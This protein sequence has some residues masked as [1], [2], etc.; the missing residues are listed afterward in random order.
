M[1]TAEAFKSPQRYLCPPQ[2]PTFILGCLPSYNQPHI[3]PT[4][5]PSTC[6]GLSPNNVRFVSLPNTS[7]A[8][9]SLRL[10]LYLSEIT[11]TQKER[12][13]KHC[14]CMYVS[15]PRF[16]TAHRH[17][18]NHIIHI[19]IYY[20]NLLGPRPVLVNALRGYQ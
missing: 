1:M 2:Q 9:L 12:K 8:V 6:V 4:K 7:C 5:P 16:E 3:Y 10:S 11:N 18:E 13:K 17:I 20:P 14:H 19:C 15:M